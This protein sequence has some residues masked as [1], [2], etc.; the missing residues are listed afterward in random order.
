MRPK[1]CKKAPP[2]ENWFITYGDMITLLM[3]FFITLAAFDDVVEPQEVSLFE[4]NYQG[5]GS[6]IGGK[7]LSKGKLS[8]L[9][10]NINTLPS[11]RQ[12][13][14]LERAKERAVSLLKEEMGKNIIDDIRIE[15]RGLI[16]SLAA[17]AFFE[18]ASAKVNIE[19]NRETLQ[20]LSSFLSSQELQDLNFKIEGHSDEI[21]TDLTG[22]WA[23]NWELS[24]KRSINIFNYI[25]NYSQIPRSQ[26]EKRFEVSAYGDTRPLMTNNT[27]EGRA[28]N[29][30]V[31]VV[32]LSEGN[33]SLPKEASITSFEKN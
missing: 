27:E 28:F 29:R 33:L 6:L 25:V 2:A 16:I 11:Q 7:T 4:M 26:F 12:G 13:R 15:Q 22:I 3:V 14:K 9:G 24:S 1:K 21:D 31:D 10:N 30:R 20:K 5:P 19:K 18:S 23:D 32:I 8:E 17:D